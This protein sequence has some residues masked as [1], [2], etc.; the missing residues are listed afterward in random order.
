MFIVI[1][2]KFC[3][4][5]LHCYLLVVLA[6]LDVFY[7]VIVGLNSGFLCVQMRNILKV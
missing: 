4:L 5:M 6:V 1:F 7:F 2:L 3:F